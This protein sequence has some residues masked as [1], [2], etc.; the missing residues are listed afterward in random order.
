MQN[1]TMDLLNGEFNRV[2]DSK[3]LSQQE[4]HNKVSYSSY[5]KKNEL[6]SLEQNMDQIQKKLTFYE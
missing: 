2:Y 3:V 1:R 5:D 6:I 4:E